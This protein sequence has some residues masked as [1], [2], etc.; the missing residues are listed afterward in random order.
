LS[1]DLDY[2]DAAHKSDTLPPDADA[3]LELISE[4]PRPSVLVHSGHGL[5]PI[6]RFAQPIYLTTAELKAEAKILVQRWQAVI[7]GAAAQRGWTTD[8]VDDLARVLRLPGSVNRKVDKETGQP[9]PPVP[10]QV[11]QTSGEVITW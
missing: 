8:K 11:I 7:T 6:W 2:Q 3:A 1:A 9:L 10:C 5:Y 4:L